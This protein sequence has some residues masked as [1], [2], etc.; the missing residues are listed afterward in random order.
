MHRKW[1]KQW[2]YC[3]Q[4]WPCRGQPSWGQIRGSCPIITLTEHA[5]SVYISSLCAFIYRWKTVFY[6]WRFISRDDLMR[7]RITSER[8]LWARLW[9]IVL[10]RLND[11][12]RYAHCR[13]HR[14]TGWDPGRL[15]EKENIN[16]AW[17]CMS[18]LLGLDTMSPALLGLL[19]L[20]PSW[21]S[22]PCNSKHK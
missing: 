10:I 9:K 17:T 7:P 12:G 4:K 13:C 5:Y 8:G 18:A 14:L 15:F 6:L 2:E 19:L 11:V 21:W 22:V 16:L 1:G 20:C 3:I